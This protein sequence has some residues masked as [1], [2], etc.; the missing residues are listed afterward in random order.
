MVPPCWGGRIC[1]VG[2]SYTT[3]IVR[4]L[5]EHRGTLFSISLLHVMHPAEFFSHLGTRVNEL[6][7]S[8]TR[9]M[10]TYEY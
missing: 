4:L 8:A 6:S 2:R 9:G 10:W 7:K 1:C 5:I 3:E